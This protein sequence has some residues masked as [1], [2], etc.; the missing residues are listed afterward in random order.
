MPPGG[1]RLKINGCAARATLSPVCERSENEDDDV[2]IRETPGGRPPATD[3]PT[4][5][6]AIAVAIQGR[7]NPLKSSESVSRQAFIIVPLGPERIPTKRHKRRTATCCTPWL[8][9]IGVISATVGL[10]FLKRF[11]QKS[12][13]RCF[14]FVVDFDSLRII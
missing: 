10:G 1:R 13:K 5:A 6:A 11:Q 4:T 9:A 7:G 12:R 2:V 8:R 3:C 14:L